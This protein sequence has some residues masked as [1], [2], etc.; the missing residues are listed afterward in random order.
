[1]RVNARN[2][3]V[4]A[5]LIAGVYLA[6]VFSIRRVPD[7]LIEALGGASGVVRD[8]GL[9]LR[10]RPPPGHD[11]ARIA[12]SLARRR[13]TVRTDAG[14]LV[15]ELPG[16]KQAEASEVVGMLTRGGIEF[17]EVLEDHS[18]DTVPRE[19][20]GGDEFVAP[21]VMIGVDMWRA[22][23]DGQR[24]TSVY[25]R[26][27]RRELL[28][29]GFAQL[30]ATGWAPPPHSVIALERYDWSRGPDD[31]HEEWRSYFV[32]DEVLL[33]GDAIDSAVAS[34]DPNTGRPIV[35]VD[36]TRDASRRFG[37]I[38]ARVVGHKLAALL[39]SEVMSAPIIN[40]EIRG[41]RAAITMGSGE[42]LEQEREAAAL[43]AVLGFGALPAGGVVEHQQWIAPAPS[44]GLLALA[45][46]LIGA[47][48][49]VVVGLLVGLV[50]R[51]TQPVWLPAP[52]QRGGPVPMRRIAVTLL[53]PAALLVLGSVRWPGTNPA[54]IA[55]L[56]RVHGERLF[57]VV[58]LGVA[59]ILAAFVVVELA[60]LLVPRW[61]RARLAPAMR[62]ASGRWVAILGA[63]LAVIQSYFAVR[64]A[65]D[66]ERGGASVFDEP[67]GS[68][69]TTM[70]SLTAGTM[71]LVIVAGMIRQH[72]LGNGYGAVIV[73]GWA[74]TAVGRMLDAPSAGHTLGLVTLGAIAC[75]TVAMLRMRI[76]DREAAL[77]VPSSGVIPLR[78]AELGLWLWLLIETRA[79]PGLGGWPSAW[80]SSWL[81][82]QIA[83]R[84]AWYLVAALV[85]L[86]PLW[87]FALSRPAIVAPLAAH[88][89]LA[90]P[91]R[92]AWR[93]ATL[94][95][96]AILLVISAASRLAVAVHADALVVGD[97]VAAMVF[98]AVVLDLHDDLRA[99]R[100]ELV[101]AWPLH[102]AQHAELVRRVLGD[103]GIECH[104]QASHLRT[105]LGFFGPFA[106]IDV[107]VP[108]AAAAEARGKIAAL[109]Q[110][111]PAR[112]FD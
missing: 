88:T 96:L 94:L 85:V 12:D 49:A 14:R 50:V 76:G 89:E 95:S 44:P 42:P 20:L 109:F 112:A 56:T 64:F 102:Q 2:A 86:V 1:M 90:P 27:E 59:P 11:A 28:E 10:Y 37:D 107:L 99:R 40:S 31:Y 5:G 21:G 70:A 106:P 52:R 81:S 62:I 9:V 91:G 72:G 66:L 22:E 80:P 97:A 71:L 35:L 100:A 54:E 43:V 4:V 32:A 111:A 33:D 45:R 55:H 104:L 46:L 60:T 41:G 39:G 101:V 78:A 30:R 74:L 61:R 82:P 6:V 83:L 92:A 17:R 29:A 7:R 67:Q 87:S 51:V 34:H 13:A 98:A 48:G 8:G 16:V 93:R 68:Y 47:V 110:D 103:A 63:V 108:P 75:A 77:R 79:V 53:A 36:F 3:A 84:S 105:L 15:V 73:S 19:R 58:D 65:H 24:H 18:L 25:L 69:L 38:T 26:A 57:T 23:H